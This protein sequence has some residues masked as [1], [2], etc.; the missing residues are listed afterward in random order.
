MP[1]WPAER[2]ETAFALTTPAG[3]TESVHMLVLAEQAKYAAS[4]PA[5]S[6]LRATR[7]RSSPESVPTACHEPA[8]IACLSVHISFALAA[9]PGSRTARKSWVA[10]FV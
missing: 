9:P 4:F 10:T 1:A 8:G 2:A 6:T 5:A 3:E 7:A